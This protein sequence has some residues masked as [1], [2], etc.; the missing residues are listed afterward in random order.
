MINRK[1]ESIKLLES[2]QTN[3]KESITIDEIE[4]ITQRIE[5]A[6]DMDEIQQIIY[7]ICLIAVMKM[8]I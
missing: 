8:M 4:E 1:S 7:N 6:E 2:I 3:L 5:S